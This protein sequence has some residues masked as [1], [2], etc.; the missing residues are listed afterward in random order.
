MTQSP[1]RARHRI[2]GPLEFVP[3]I[4]LPEQWQVPTA[5]RPPI[6]R[7]F[8]AVLDEAYRNLRAE[9]DSG[10][11][12]LAWFRCEARTLFAF[13]FVCDVLE[14]DPGVYRRLAENVW[15]R[16]F[17]VARHV[18]RAVSKSDARRIGA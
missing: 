7:L 12:S 11:E 1:A 5:H 14:I 3:E 16:K 8:S 15:S 17:H 9:T 10:R 2:V 4:V 6:I 13:R 18:R